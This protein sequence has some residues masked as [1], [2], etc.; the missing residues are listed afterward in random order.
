[1]CVYVCMYVHVCG[2]FVCEHACVCA[3][4]RITGST[5]LAF[6]GAL[7]VWKQPT[8]PKEI[9]KK[10]KGWCKENYGYLSHRKIPS[11]FV[12]SAKACYYSS[13]MPE[14]LLE[15]VL[16]WYCGE[17]NVMTTL[18]QVLINL[19]EKIEVCA[20]VSE[21]MTCDSQEKQLGIKLT[22]H[23]P[24]GL[25]THKHHVYTYQLHV[26]CIYHPCVSR[27]LPTLLTSGL[28]FTSF[29]LL[30]ASARTFFSSLFSSLSAS[31][32]DL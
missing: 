20:V 28:T 26:H 30:P 23:Q 11:F 6:Q 16:H 21:N 9:Q 24:D 25:Q 1:M 18:T 12:W 7:P 15:F 31:I 32:A 14:K 29:C 8:D 10:R 17:A 2:V 4:V 13:D 19:I 3:C 22:L 27:S 5:H